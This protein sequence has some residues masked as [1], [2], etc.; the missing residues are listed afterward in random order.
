VAPQAPSAAKAP[1]VASGPM[2]WSCRQ[3]ITGPMQGCPGCGARYHRSDVPT[4]QAGKLE[5][6]VNCSAAATTFVLA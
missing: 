5:A 2:C 4:C 3:T 6:C 1:A